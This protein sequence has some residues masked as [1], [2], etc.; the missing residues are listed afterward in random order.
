MAPSPACT[1]ARTRSAATAPPM[2][3][4]LPPPVASSASQPSVALADN[5]AGWSYRSRLSAAIARLDPESSA[6][7]PSFSRTIPVD[8][9]SADD[10]N[11]DNDD[12]FDM[13]KYL[14]ICAAARQFHESHE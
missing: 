3:L 6:E 9:A 12:D 13:K 11:N 2:L 14:A 10:D 5:D 8:E 7:A 1:R 4:P